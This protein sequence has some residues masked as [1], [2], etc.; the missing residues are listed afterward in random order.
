MRRR[1]GYRLI[2]VG[3][4]SLLATASFSAH[5]EAY[6]WPYLPSKPVGSRLGRAKI[7]TAKVPSHSPR[8][9]VDDANVS[10]GVD[11]ED[12]AD[13]DPLLSTTLLNPS[14]LQQILDTAQE[15]AE[16]AG[17]V[18]RSNIGCCSATADECEIKFSI[19]DIVTQYDQ[20]AQQAVEEIVRSRYPNHSFLGEEDVDPGAVASASALDAFLQNQQ[21]SP[22]LWICDPIDVRIDP[23]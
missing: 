4:A 18:I 22:F 7:P 3:V 5:T 20:Q 14:E 9:C 8:S 1:Q 10:T 23:C 16:A 21:L 17:R 13:K 2:A 6:L 11:V 19:K 15:A 12:D